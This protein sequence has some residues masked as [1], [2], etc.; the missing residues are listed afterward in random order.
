MTM[1]DAFA[2]L[3]FPRELNLDADTVRARFQ[4]L[5]LS[6][7]PDCGGEAGDY[8]EL[9]E[10]EAILGTPYKRWRHWAEL[11]GWKQGARIVE[12]DDSIAEDF[13]RV[14][15]LLRR[16]REAV[17]ARISSGSVIARALAER[18]SIFLLGEISAKLGELSSKEAMILARAGEYLL[19]GEAGKLSG[20]LSCLAKWTRELQE[21]VS[22]LAG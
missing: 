1:M 5:S 6:R 8:R 22:A 12:M 9:V 7:H 2:V 11:H 10:A 21:A 14:G 16:A 18:N 15:D 20:E 13:E 19:P 4:E 3:G 17:Q